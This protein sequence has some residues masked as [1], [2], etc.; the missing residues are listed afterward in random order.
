MRRELAEVK[1]EALAARE[2][3]ESLRKELEEEREKGRR[4]SRRR[5]VIDDSPPSSSKG[6]KAEYKTFETG[7]PEEPPDMEEAPMEIEIASEE[8]PPRGGK[9]L[10]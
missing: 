8:L 9:G 5:V 6:R 10:R 3:A 1:R 4:M 2:E 7:D